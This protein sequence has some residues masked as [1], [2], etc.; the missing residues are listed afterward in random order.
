MCVCV[1]VCNMFIFISSVII[2]IY[3]YIYIYIKCLFLL[4]YFYLYI[5]NNSSR[6]DIPLNRISSTK[7]NDLREICW[8]NKK[9]YLSKLSFSKNFNKFKV[10]SGELWDWVV[11]TKQQIGIGYCIDIVATDPLQTRNVGHMHIDNVCSSVQCFII[12]GFV[13]SI[14]HDW[15]TFRWPRGAW[16]QGHCQRRLGHVRDCIITRIWNVEQNGCFSQYKEL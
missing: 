1:C 6:I 11:N 14:P 9:T 10:I 15:C 13:Q 5:L 16:W 7:K 2:Y 12:W 3:I 8:V 4:I